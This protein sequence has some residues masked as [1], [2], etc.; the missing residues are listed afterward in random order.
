MKV[1]KK[2]KRNNTLDNPLV[3][4]KFRESESNQECLEAP[5]LEKKTHWF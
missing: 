5:Y 4:V 3:S 2:L 1:L